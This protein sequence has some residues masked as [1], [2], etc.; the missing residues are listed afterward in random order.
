[1][2]RNLRDIRKLIFI[3]TAVVA[4]FYL[5]LAALNVLCQQL[6]TGSSGLEGL[7]T[8]AL[9]DTARLFV[10]ELGVF[11]LPFWQIGVIRGAI[12]KHRN[13]RLDGALTSGFYRFGPV[14]G[15][16]LLTG[17]ALIAAM[18][19]AIQAASVVYTMTQPGQETSTY[20]ATYMEK[21][22]DPM[23][24]LENI[25]MP[26]LLERMAPVLVVAV[27]LGIPAVYWVWCRFRFAPYLVM[28]DEKIRGI[29]SMIRSFSLA[30]RQTEA[31]IRLDLHYWWYYLLTLLTAAVG[32]GDL[33]LIALGV[34]INKTVLLFA[35]LG[36]S[37]VLRLAM[38]WWLQP[39]VE[40]AYAAFY[41]KRKREAEE[42]KKEA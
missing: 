2:K 4:G 6:S 10:Q 5:L 16:Q 11:L 21:T 31:F 1:M 32:Y 12:C 17:L 36:V 29:P 26:E 22:A 18:I 20:L 13:E 33:I 8:R 38:A 3:S 37:S 39:R 34:Q 9:L 35:A 19:A 30:K 24:A 28:D 7:K 42:T 15:M 27:I 41:D 25:P 40:L 23:A 14:L